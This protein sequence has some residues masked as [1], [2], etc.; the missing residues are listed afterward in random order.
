MW[1]FPQRSPAQNN[2]FH[3]IH[4]PKHSEEKYSGMVRVVSQEI[5][6]LL[7]VPICHIVKSCCLMKASICKTG[8]N[9]I[10]FF[11]VTKQQMKS[12]RKHCLPVA[13]YLSATLRRNAAPS[14]FLKVLLNEIPLIIVGIICRIFAHVGEHTTCFFWEI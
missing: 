5:S 4:F 14:Q 7:K 1:N 9:K 6:V 2:I 13:E 10:L 8:S 12:I 3:K 11:Y